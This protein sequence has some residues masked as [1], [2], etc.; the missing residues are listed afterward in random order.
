MYFIVWW[1]IDFNGEIGRKVVQCDDDGLLCA[2]Y[3]LFP[4]KY[5]EIQLYMPEL[6]QFLQS[7]IV[8]FFMEGPFS[9]RH[10]QKERFL[11]W[12][13]DRPQFDAKIGKT[14]SGSPI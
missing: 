14:L 12:D 2:C 6:A 11:L 13:V 9:S 5:L 7:L 1:Y 4:P 10:E 8:K 3:T